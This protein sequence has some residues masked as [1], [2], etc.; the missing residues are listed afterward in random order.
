MNKIQKIIFID[1][2]IFFFFKKKV[3]FIKINIII[4]KMTAY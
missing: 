4:I 3:N 1:D 2:L